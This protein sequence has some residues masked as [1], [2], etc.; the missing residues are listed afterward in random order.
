MNA[1]C[2]GRFWLQ[3]NGRFLS[4]NSIKLDLPPNLILRGNQEGE[5][6]IIVMASLYP[7]NLKR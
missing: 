2:H 1:G 4:L 5:Q 3:K 7:A 6:N